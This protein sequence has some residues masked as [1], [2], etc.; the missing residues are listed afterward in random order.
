[1]VVLRSFKAESQE[2]GLLQVRHP[3]AI[4]WNDNTFTSL[5]WMVVSLLSQWG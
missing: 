2:W 3:R 5:R 4:G 1:V